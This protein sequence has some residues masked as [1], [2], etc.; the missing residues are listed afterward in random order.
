MSQKVQSVRTRARSAVKPYTFVS[1][2]VFHDAWSSPDSSR[3]ANPVRDN[4]LLVFSAVAGMTVAAICHT[5]KDQADSRIEITS[6]ALYQA[7]SLLIFVNGS[8]CIF[9]FN[10]FFPCLFILACLRSYTYRPRIKDRDGS[11]C[12]FHIEL[13]TP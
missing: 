7:V 8:F 5:C 12:L 4:L 1:K 11:S 2:N 9:T 13:E 6:L 10:I 3:K